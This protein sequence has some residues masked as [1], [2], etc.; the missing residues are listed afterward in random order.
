[1]SHNKGKTMQHKHGKRQHVK[2]GQRFWQAP[3]LFP[4]QHKHWMAD[5]RTLKILK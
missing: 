3:A 4:F 1:M 5:H 2:T